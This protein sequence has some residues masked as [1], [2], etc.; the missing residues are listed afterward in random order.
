MIIKYKDFIG[1]ADIKNNKHI[2]IDCFKKADKEN[3]AVLTEDQINDDN[4]CI[5]DDCKVAM[6]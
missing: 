5:C 1:Y 3:I 4:V 2:C 6:W